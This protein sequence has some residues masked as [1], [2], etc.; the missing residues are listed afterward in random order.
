MTTAGTRRRL[1]EKLFPTNGD[2]TPDIISLNAHFDHRRALPALDNT[3]KTEVDLFE[4]STVFASAPDALTGR[5]TFSM[6]CHSGLAVSDATIGVLADDFAQGF[7]RQGGIYVGNTGYGYGDTETVAYS[8]RLME[9][10]ADEL[11][12]PILF[13]R[14]TTAGQALQ[15]AKNTFFSELGNVSVYDEKALM[16]ATFYGLPFYRLSVE[17][18]APLRRRPP[19][20]RS[21]R[22]PATR[23]RRSPSPRTTRR[24]PSRRRRGSSSSTGTR[25]ATRSS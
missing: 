9:L 4:A 5:I 8:E 22:S 3:N 12:N 15:F 2:P 1:T 19:P 11:V 13:D 25:L 17:P 21:T 10:F 24:S 14:P 6:G 16:E 23:S 18:E 20:R 7:T